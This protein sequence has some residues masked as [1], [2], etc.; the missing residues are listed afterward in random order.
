MLK[1]IYSRKSGHSVAQE[2]NVGKT[3]I[4]GIVRD[5]EE[6]VRKLEAGEQSE[7][8]YTKVRIFFCE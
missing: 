3:Q 7:K 5:R 1:S 2:F 8:K 6:I 4:Q